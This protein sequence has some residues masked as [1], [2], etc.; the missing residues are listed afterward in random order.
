MHTPLVSVVIPTYN[1]PTFLREALESVLA[2]TFADYE[3]IVVNDGSTD[4]TAEQLKAYGNRLRVITQDNQGIGP[5]RNRGMDEAIGRYIAFLDH[6]DIWHPAKLET[7]V[8]FMRSHPHC[9][10]SSVPFAYTSSPELVVFD[11]SI[12]DSEGIV[13]DAL[14]VFAG[15]VIFLLTSA[16]MI[17]RLKAGDLRYATRRD[18]IEDLPLQLR[19][20]TRGP[21]GI[22]GDKI[23]VMYRVHASN[24]SKSALIYE[25]GILLLR[26]IAQNGGFEPVSKRDRKAIEEFIS[27]Y[28]R[29]SAV[30]LL[31]A[32]LRRRSFQCYIREFSHQMRARRVK[33]LLLFPLLG[34]MPQFILRRRWSADDN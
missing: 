20:L 18:C 12:R 19:L 17:D 14:H 2:Q 13:R 6:D 33:F 8:A 26:E 32:R 11:L 3:I 27:F 1:Q 7:Q 29:I 34:I 22:A 24:A 21:V 31:R 10:G 25:N 23:L 5:A 30:R 15:G 9:V 28:G 4:D 16:L